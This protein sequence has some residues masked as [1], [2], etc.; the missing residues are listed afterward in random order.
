MRAARARAPGRVPSGVLAAGGGWMAVSRARRRAPSA[1]SRSATAR[2]S[3][4]TVRR[5]SI[6][7]MA[8]WPRSRRA[9]RCSP[10]SDRGT[11][12]MTHERAEDVAVGGAQGRG[13]V[14]PDVGTAG[15]V[16]VVGEARVR[17]RVR[18]LHEV[19]L[20]DGVGAEGVVARGLRRGQ[21]DPGLEPLAVRVQQ[22][23]ERDGRAADGGRDARQGVEVR[24]GRGVEDVGVPQ[25]LKPFA[26]AVGPARGLH[27]TRYPR[28]FWSK[29]RRSSKAS[30]L[31]R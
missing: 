23:H 4:A 13:R 3:S 21:A 1:L 19:R 29:T 11:W 15:H 9:E 18:D 30:G 6:W 24:F 28:C 25:R 5:I 8:C 10:V 20:Q 2:R 17:L 26:L 22:A 27:R 31:A 7:A 16:R 14:E 12:S